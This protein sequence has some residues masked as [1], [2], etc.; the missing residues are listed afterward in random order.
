MANEVNLVITYA[1]IVNWKMLI[2]LIL[3]AVAVVVQ[4]THPYWT[5]LFLV[6]ML[7]YF[8]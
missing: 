7:K 4:T 1:I 8:V 2:N 5:M 6:V 3:L